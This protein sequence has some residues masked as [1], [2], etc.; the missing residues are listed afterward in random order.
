MNQKV[1]LIEIL[2]PEMD[3][4]FVALN[5]PEKS[6]NNGHYF[7]GSWSYWNLL[8]KSG[9]IVHPVKS[10][11]TGDDEVFRSNGINFKNQIYGVTDLCHDIVQTNSSKVTVNKLRVQR[12]LSLLDTHKV[13]ILCL[14]HSKVGK[15]FS[16][17]QGIDR[18]KKYGSI[19]KI[20][21]SL[22]Y[23]MPFHCASI[24]DKEKYYQK[25]IYGISK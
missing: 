14:L 9:L 3:I 21:G 20:N 22:I 23:E 8:L 6:N 2:H 13:K 19:G 24:Q 18:T 16:R 5:P 4:L 11:L 7:S 17:V 12:I 10:P 15:A 25:L 1:N